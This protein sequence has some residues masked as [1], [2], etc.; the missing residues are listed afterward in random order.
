M[1]PTGPTPADSREVK[2]WITVLMNRSHALGSFTAVATS[3]HTVIM[4]CLQ[5]CRIALRLALRCVQTGVL[6]ETLLDPS[7]TGLWAYRNTF[8]KQFRATTQEELRRH[9]KSHHLTIKTFVLIETRLHIFC[10]TASWAF[11]N[12]FQYAV[13]S[14]SWHRIAHSHQQARGVGPA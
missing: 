6:I 10:A 3:D 8:S 5:G 13:P 7:A 12:I 9:S 11:G 2:F 14:C 1:W 4:S